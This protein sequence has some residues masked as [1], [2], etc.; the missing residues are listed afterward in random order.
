MHH[1]KVDKQRSK[2]PPPLAILRGGAKVS[3][4]RQLHTIGRVPKAR[5]CQQ[6]QCEH[7]D[8]HCQQPRGDGHAA[9]WCCHQGGQAGVLV[10]WGC[11]G[12]IGGCHGVV[13]LH[14]STAALWR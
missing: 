11:C 12:W 1:A 13:G 14:R 7:D 3:A 6:H 10:W 8:I 4:P 9:R 2:Q 5:A